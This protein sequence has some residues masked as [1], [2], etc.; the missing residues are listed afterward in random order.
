MATRCSK[1]VTFLKLSFSR[2]QNALISESQRAVLSPGQKDK[3]KVIKRLTLT[4]RA[5]SC[6]ELTLMSL[7]LKCS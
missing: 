6:A 4:M 1:A 5:I 2:L 3:T 7:M